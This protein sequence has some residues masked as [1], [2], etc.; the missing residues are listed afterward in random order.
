MKA[1]TVIRTMSLRPC[2]YEEQ[3]TVIPLSGQ[4]TNWI[5][6]FTACKNAKLDTVLYNINSIMQIWINVIHHT[7]GL[8]VYSYLSMEC[9]F[10]VNSSV[11]SNIMVK[12]ICV[13]LQIEK[14]DT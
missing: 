11:G 5:P 10:V 13:F 1:Q 2:M 9:I 8:C 3:N 14:Q 4:L 6:C 7:Y 12:E